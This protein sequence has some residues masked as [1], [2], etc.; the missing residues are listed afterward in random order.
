MK[1]INRSLAILRPKQ[2]F[3]DWINS[4]SPDVPPMTLEAVNDDCN[5]ILIPEYNTDQDAKAFIKSR[6]SEI[7]ET[8]LSGWITDEDMWPKN[9]TFKMFKKWFDVELHSMVFDLGK[10]EIMADDYDF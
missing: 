4:S 9:R 2:P 10:Y 7:F 6:C 1:T 5:A 8:E 3:I